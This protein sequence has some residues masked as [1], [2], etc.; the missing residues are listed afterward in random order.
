MGELRVEFSCTLCGLVDQPCYVPEREESEDV[1]KWFQDVLT[2]SLY[3]RHKQLSP[4][5][6]SRNLKNLKIPITGANYIGEVPKS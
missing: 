3:E 4:D 2:P 6:P 5:C 1:A